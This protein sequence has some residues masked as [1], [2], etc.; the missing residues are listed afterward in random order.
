MQLRHQLVGMAL[1]ETV[2]RVRIPSGFQAKRAFQDKDHPVPHVRADLCVHFPIPEAVPAQIIG[3]ERAQS[4]WQP[5][6]LREN[7]I[8]LCG[9]RGAA[10]V[11]Q[12]DCFF[13]SEE[14]RKKRSLKAFRELS[15]VESSVWAG[16]H[17]ERLYSPRGVSTIDRG[18]VC[19]WQETFYRAVS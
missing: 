12:D 13:N 15:F 16:G 2:L 14:G 4:S 9:Q 7:P 8:N 10:V 6:F 17:I 19:P 1:L 3:I 18:R 5:G 11:R